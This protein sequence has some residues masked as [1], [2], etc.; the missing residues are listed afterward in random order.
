MKDIKN[1]IYENKRL[2]TEKELT[3]QFFVSRITARKALNH[4]AEIGVVVRISGRGT[5]VKKGNTVLEGA[6]IVF[7]HM[8]TVALVMGGYSPSF[9]LDIVNAALPAAEEEGVH[10]I[11]KDT[12]ND[13][14]REIKIME[15]LKD[16]GVDGIIIQPAHGEIYSQWLINAVF[17][18]FPIVMIDR[19]LPG[20]D[21]PF[22]GVDN[23]RL[24]EIAV[25]HLIEMGHRNISLIALEDDKTSTLRARMDG[26]SRALN[27]HNIPVDRRMWITNLA[28]RAKEA[29]MDKNHVSAHA[30]YMRAIAEHLH[31]HPEITAVLGTEFVASQAAMDA[32]QASGWSIPREL[33]IVG[34]DCEANGIGLY[35]LTHVRQPQAEMGRTAVKMISSILRGEKLDHPH[36]LIEG[37]WVQGNTIAPP[38]KK[39]DISWE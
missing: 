32:V 8:P 21:A 33:S 20:I 15:E 28:D 9:G 14:A 17:D 35:R 11:L 36:R 29:G 26:F 24:S 27:S 25:N 3:E 16:S 6:N 12:G 34:F 23:E 4:L 13:Q 39:P 30:L 38:E 2:P 37:E 1:G 31:R 22:V 10:I 19:F 18:K 5:F 7:R